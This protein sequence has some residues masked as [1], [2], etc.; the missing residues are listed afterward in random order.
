MRWLIPAPVVA[1]RESVSEVEYKREH[2][3]WCGPPDSTERK[4]TSDLNYNSET[5]LKK[6]LKRGVL[7]INK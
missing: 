5:V 2:E 4:R 7:R 3:V 1:P 6:Y